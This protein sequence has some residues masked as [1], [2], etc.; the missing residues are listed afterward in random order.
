M[1]NWKDYL[2]YIV[3]YHQV[4]K[5]YKLMHEYAMT[6]LTLLREKLIGLFYWS[7]SLVSCQKMVSWASVNILQN[8]YFCSRIPICS[9]FHLVIL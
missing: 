6:E 1:S 8:A 4:R 2:K 9:L 3:I 5:Q 7:S